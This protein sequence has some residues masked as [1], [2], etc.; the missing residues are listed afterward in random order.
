MSKNLDQI[1]KGFTV[2]N[3]NKKHEKNRT[4]EI[5]VNKINSS[6]ERNS[7]DLNF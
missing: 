6:I 2:E 3:L 1:F 5:K 7:E 4:D